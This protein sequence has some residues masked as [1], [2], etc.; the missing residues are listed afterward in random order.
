MVE[1]LMGK[2]GGGED[3]CF[4]GRRNSWLTMFLIANNFFLEDNVVDKWVWFHYSDE[5]YTMKKVL[6]KLLLKLSGPYLTFSQ[7]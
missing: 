4:P 1:V 6:I 7:I 5:G 3:D 2:N